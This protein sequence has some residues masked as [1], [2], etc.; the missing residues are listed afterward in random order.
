M[1]TVLAWPNVDLQAEATLLFARH[2][3]PLSASA[4]PCTSAQNAKVAACIDPALFRTFPTL[5]R[6][7]IHLLSIMD[8]AGSLMEKHAFL[9]NRYHQVGVLPCVVPGQIH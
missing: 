1:C 5:A 6:T 2:D 9:W 4:V 8:L 7:M 3:C